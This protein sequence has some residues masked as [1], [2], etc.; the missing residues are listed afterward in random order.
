[1][2]PLYGPFTTD[3][4]LTLA[5]AGDMLAL[6]PVTGCRDLS[7]RLT[8]LAQTHRPGTEQVTEAITLG[9]SVQRALSLEAAPDRWLDDVAAFDPE[10]QNEI[11]ADLID[12]RRGQ[13]EQVEQALSVL[14]T[15]TDRSAHEANALI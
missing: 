9:Q 12:Q 1:M 8:C 5:A 3:Q 4:R 11:I 6:L 14:R 15:L 13:S 7:T 10:T 2:N